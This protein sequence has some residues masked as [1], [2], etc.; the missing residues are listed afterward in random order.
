[1]RT[2]SQLELLRHDLGKLTAAVSALVNHQVHNGAARAESILDR[3][4]ESSRDWVEHH[5]KDRPSQSLGIA[6]GVGFVLGLI[7]SRRH[8]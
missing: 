3:N 2:Q 5:V 6:V 7:A 8:S 4:I 1:M